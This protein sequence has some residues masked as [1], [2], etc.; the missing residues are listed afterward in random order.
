MRELRVLVSDTL[1][2]SLLATWRELYEADA[3]YAITQTPLTRCRYE[4]DS[5]IL[6]IK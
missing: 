5:G 1:Q 6:G 4:H 3:L 2:R